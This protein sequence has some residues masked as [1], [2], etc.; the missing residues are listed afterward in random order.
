MSNADPVRALYA[1]DYGEIIWTAGALAG[2]RWCWSA[3]APAVHIS[4]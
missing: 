1:A 4:G 3:R 2:M